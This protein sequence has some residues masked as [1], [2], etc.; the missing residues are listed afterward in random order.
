MALRPMM[1]TPAVGSSTP[2][3]TSVQPEV[4]AV[5]D[6][7]SSNREGSAL[8]DVLPSLLSMPAK[9]TENNEETKRVS[10]D[11]EATR[12]NHEPSRHRHDESDSDSSYEDSR[13]SARYRG[14]YRHKRRA[15]RLVRE[16]KYG[17][18]VGGRRNERGRNDDEQPFS[19][20][21]LKLK[22]FAADI[23]GALPRGD[24]FVQ[25][26]RC[27]LFC[28]MAWSVNSI[29]FSSLQIF[30]AENAGG[31]LLVNASVEGGA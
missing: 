4:A 10:E 8:S 3:E 25:A 26:M 30:R 16:R 7:T 9:R 24:V 6:N 12:G 27:G 22:V 15:G 1:S 28:A 5:A 11:H 18:P 21:V 13:G 14:G 2:A 29:I 31:E 17:R 19:S 23:F 20:P